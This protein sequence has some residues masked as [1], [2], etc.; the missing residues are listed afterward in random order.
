MN[1][2]DNNKKEIINFYPS[3]K[4]K[5]NFKQDQN[6]EIINNCNSN[7]DNSTCDAA[8]CNNSASITLILPI[9]GTNNR[10][11]K[12]SI[13]IQVCKYCKSKFE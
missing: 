5:Q 13:S 1:I 10:S 9:T 4:A 12:S 2:S 3:E 8:N 7:N 11:N 6:Y